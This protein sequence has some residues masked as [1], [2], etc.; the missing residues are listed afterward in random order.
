VRLA[1]SPKITRELVGD[2]KVSVRPDAFD[3]DI[4]ERSAKA[5]ESAPNF[6]TIFVLEILNV[7]PAKRTWITQVLVIIRK[8]WA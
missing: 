3:S 4:G 5:R 1:R 8:Y 2:S 7:F 6:A